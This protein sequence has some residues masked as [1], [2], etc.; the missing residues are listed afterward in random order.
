MGIF[1]KRIKRVPS[2]AYRSEAFDYYFAK[3]IDDGKDEI[4]AA[5]QAEKFADIIAKNKKLPDSPPPPMNGLQKGVMYV[6]QI[7]SLKEEHPEVWSLATGVLGGLIGGFTG[8]A[9]V[10][11]QEEPPQEHIDFEHLD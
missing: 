10:S 8:I 1:D 9:T 6:K 4:I 11:T 5:E 7:A 2:F 3:L